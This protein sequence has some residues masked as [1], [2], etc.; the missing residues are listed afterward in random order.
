MASGI[1]ATAYVPREGHATELDTAT[2]VLGDLPV[3]MD[4][5]TKTD[6]SAIIDAPIEGWLKTLASN[7]RSFT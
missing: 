6:H 4:D 5:F 2:N 7:Q 1:A 3:V